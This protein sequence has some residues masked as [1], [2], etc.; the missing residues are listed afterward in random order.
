MK[1]V[2][3][4]WGGA[5]HQFKEKDIKFYH[6]ECYVAKTNDEQFK[7]GNQMVFVWDG[8]NR[9]LMEEFNYPY[10]YMGESSKLDIEFNF[11]YK[12]YALKKAMELYDEILFLDW[13]FFITKELDDQFFE[14]LKNKGDIQMPLYFYPKELLDLFKSMNLD[15]KKVSKYY[16]NLY[17]QM[18]IHCR[19]EFNEGL[20]IPN[21]GFIYCRDKHF[22]N[23][24]LDIQKNK[25]ITTNIEELSAMVYFNQNVNSMDE[26]IKT[27]EPIVCHGKTETEMMGKQILLNEHTNQKLKKTLYFNHI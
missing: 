22:F 2:R 4:L 11:L 12:I 20:V 3:C 1:I 10:H 21:A 18:I 6:N 25:N 14:L 13:D 24:I 7:L 27:I 23:N 19:W 16:N 15:N 5:N 17:E 8:V 9:D 26:Y